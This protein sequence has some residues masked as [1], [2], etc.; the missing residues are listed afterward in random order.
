MMDWKSRFSLGLL[1]VLLSLSGAW[2]VGEAGAL[3]VVY[4]KADPGSVALAKYYASKRNIPADRLVGLTCPLT[5]EITREEYNTT[6]AGPFK[7]IFSQKG[8]WKWQGGRI[9]DSKIRFVVLMRGMPLKVKSKGLEV[10]PRKD[11]PQPIASRDEAS[12]DS[13]LAAMGLGEVSASGLVPNPFFRRF[14]P[15]VDSITDPGLLL[16]CRLDAISDLTV[17]AM[18]DDAISTERTGLWGWGY[19]DSRGIKDGGYA[20]GDQWLTDLAG[21][22]REKGV[23]VLWDKAPEIFP[24]GYPVTDA[25]VYYGWYTDNVAGPFADSTMQ[26]R[27]GAVAVHIHSF[28]ASTLRNPATNWCGPLL[29]RG[30]A[31]TLG[32]VYEPYLTLTA[33]LDVFQDRLMAGFTFAESAYMSMR[34]LSW[35]NVVIGDPLYRPYVAWQQLAVSGKPADDW[36]KYREIVIGKD[37]SVSGAS[38]ELTDAAKKTGNSMFLESLAAAEAD[39]SDF[40]QALLLV[41]QALEMKNKPLVRFRLVLEKIGLLR[42]TGKISDIRTLLAKERGLVPGA[43]QGVL[44]DAIHRQLFPPPPTPTPAAPPPGSP[45][46]RK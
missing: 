9:V 44:L 34:A 42:A 2:A 31:A 36:Q 7:D 5:E 3:V 45:P 30:A 43:N 11:Q 15:I 10:L 20:E 40:P 27:P 6:I 13:E 25:A 1:A 26:F 39:D 22:M 19:V 17:K 14:A 16:V 8:W 38:L 33:H 12:V 4:N 18:I 23:P 28:S 37:G 29:E 46:I 32:N 35:M 24:L 41:N 21:Q